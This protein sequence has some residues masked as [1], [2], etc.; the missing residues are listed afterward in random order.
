MRFLFFFILLFSTLPI[1]GQEKDTLVII[2]NFVEGKVD[3]IFVDT[4]SQTAWITIGN[5]STEYTF[6]PPDAT[7]AKTKEKWHADRTTTRKDTSLSEEL[8]HRY[9]PIIIHDDDGNS[10]TIY[11]DGTI[12]N[13]TYFA[14]SSDYLSVTADETATFTQHAEENYGF[15]AKK[16]TIFT[17]L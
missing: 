14:I 6:D 15:D 2:P 3:N 5:D 13:G 10:Y 11:P 4:T 9:Y 7:P 17:W 1:F 12:E 16:H 8:S